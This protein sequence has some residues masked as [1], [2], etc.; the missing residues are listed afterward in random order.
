MG[1]GVGKGVGE[2]VGERVGE[3]V[4][5]QEGLLC[6]PTGAPAS[7]TSSRS[8]AATRLLLVPPQSTQIFPPGSRCGQ[9]V[10]PLL[11]AALPLLLAAA[12]RFPTRASSK[13]SGWLAIVDAE[14]W[15]RS[16]SVGPQ[17]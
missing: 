5:E 2:G 13:T 17:L 8:R 10:L 16:R 11:L 4:G 12:I 6:C 3:R 1:E 15:C 9:A 7:L 14:Y